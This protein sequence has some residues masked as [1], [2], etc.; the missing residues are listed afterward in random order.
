VITVHVHRPSAGVT[1][2]DAERQEYVT[3][4][5]YLPPTAIDLRGV[6]ETGSISLDIN[7]SS[8]GI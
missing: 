2:V 1:V 7:V 5:C 8:V 4:W 3:I 6:E